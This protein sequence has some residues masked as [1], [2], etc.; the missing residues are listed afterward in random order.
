MK[1]P[2]TG[3]RELSRMRWRA[4]RSSDVAL[5]T[6]SH[7]SAKGLPGPGPKVPMLRQPQRPSRDLSHRDRHGQ[8]PPADPDPVRRHD[9]WYLEQGSRAAL[10]VH[11]LATDG[12]QVKAG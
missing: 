10:A 5:G 4:V 11:A 8:G 7:S 1:L 3:S 6:S 9:G 2:F 12:Q